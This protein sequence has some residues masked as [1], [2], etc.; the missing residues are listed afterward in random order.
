MRLRVTRVGLRERGFVTRELD[1]L[2]FS[3]NAPHRAQ[4]FAKC[5]HM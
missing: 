3:Q 5:T 1:S 4:R 2:P